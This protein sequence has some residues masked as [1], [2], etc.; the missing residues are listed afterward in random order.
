MKTKHLR[1]QSPYWCGVLLLYLMACLGS[2]HDDE[3]SSGGY[4]P[5]KPIAFTDFSP[6]EGSLRTQLHIYGE[7][8]GNDPSKIHIWIGGQPTTTIGC[9]NKEIYCM[10]P[11]RAFE[12]NV[13]ISVESAD[14]K[15][16]P[17]EYEFEKRFQYISKS[18]VS[19]L[20]GNEDEKGNSSDIDG[21][22]ETA[23]FGNV[24]W[25]LLDTFGITKS[26]LVCGAGGPVRRVDL[27][28]GTVS[29]VT[30]NGQS[31][32][33]NM[34]YMTLDASGDT[35]FISDDHGQNHKDMREVAYFLRSEN[36]R[37]ARAYVYD[38]TGYCSAYH[39]IEKALYYNT[40]WKGA[41][42][43]AVYDPVTQ[44]MVGEELFSVYESRDEHTYMTIHPHGNYMYI[45]GANC[46]YKSEYNWDT[47]KFQSPTIF[48]GRLGES[49]YVDAPGTTARFSWPYQGTFVKNEEYVKA[50]KEDIYDFYLCDRNAHCIRKI[51][52]E[53]IVSTFAGR[54]SISSDGQVNGYIDGDLR[55]EARF[56][57]PCGIA[58][59]EKTQ[60]FY[61][62]DKENH[63]IRTIS[64]E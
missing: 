12:G 62:A 29:T 28:E 4:D 6:S 61:I 14:G 55:K 44:G 59:D 10:V 11:P 35:L 23:R 51:T 41:I 50:G 58:Y 42:Q 52:P 49:N 8:F 21:N 53:G 45:T 2:C 9:N 43:K 56:D 19:T 63:R 26:L 64:V 46:I 39:P 32:F 54:G 38:R 24:E 13:K 25:L 16:E 31:S 27:E 37:K 33:R 18:S 1:K 17:L 47:K 5:S 20:V 22:L 30:T 57:S 36:F 3:T 34:Q 15:S 40:Y 7:N 48:V 60:T